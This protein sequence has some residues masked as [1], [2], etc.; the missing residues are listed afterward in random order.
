M[1]L[2]FDANRLIVL[3]IIQSYLVVNLYQTAKDAIINISIGEYVCMMPGTYSNAF[4]L[5]VKHF[6]NV[7]PHVLLLLSMELCSCQMRLMPQ[8]LLPVPSIKNTC[9][10]HTS[11]VT[12]T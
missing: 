2:A 4:V 10:K 9:L 12:S 11:T 8:F 3:S 1:S 5:M 7:L 6:R